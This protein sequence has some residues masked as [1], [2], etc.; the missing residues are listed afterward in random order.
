MNVER[1]STICT[2]RNLW[3]ASLKRKNVLIGSKSSKDEL[4]A[5]QLLNVSKQVQ[6]L[7]LQVRRLLDETSG[8]YK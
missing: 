3:S 6:D 8:G 5:W 4:P 7:W 1:T 2:R